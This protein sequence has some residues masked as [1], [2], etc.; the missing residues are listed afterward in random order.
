MTMKSCV[1]RLGTS[2]YI[3]LG[4]VTFVITDTGSTSFIDKVPEEARRGTPS[5][6]N[7][8]KTPTGVRAI[9]EVVARIADKLDL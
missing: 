4:E 3:P 2:T 6:D 9:I 1:Y 8:G 5:D 7:S